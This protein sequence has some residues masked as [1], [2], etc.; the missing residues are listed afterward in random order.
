MRLWLLLFLAA[1]T[2]LSACNKPPQKAGTLGAPTKPPPTGTVIPAEYR[3]PLPADPLTLD[4]AHI[5][6][7]VSDSVA[8]R[9]FSQLVRFAPDL[10]IVDDL[11]ESHTISADG[12]EYSFKLRQ[13][14]KFHNGRELTADDVAYSLPPAARSGD[15]R[16]ARQPAV[17]RQGRAG[18]PRW[19]ER[20][21]IPGIVVV[22]PTHDQARCWRS[23]T[24]HS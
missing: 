21:T 1:L 7:T 12:L 10:S 4:P 23:P 3:F 24:R 11:A 2:L 22:D 13:G 9:I 19:Q 14:V 5:T 17:L 20:R 16:R 8:R 15:Q 18:L 6:D